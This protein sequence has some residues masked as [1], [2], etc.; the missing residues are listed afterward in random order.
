MKRDA[1]KVI[2]HALL[3]LPTESHW[4]QGKAADADGGVCAAYALFVSLCEATGHRD[5]TAPT[6][7]EFDELADRCVTAIMREANSAFDTPRYEGITQWNDD[8]RTS[9]EEVRLVMKRAAGWLV[10]EETSAA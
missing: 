1:S 8:P 10:H 2:E 6:T 4:V 3:L 9:F 7:P 5:L